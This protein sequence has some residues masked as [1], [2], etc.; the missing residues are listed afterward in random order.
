MPPSPARTSRRLSSKTADR[1]ACLSRVAVRAYVD[2]EEFD[3]TD[4]EENNLLHAAVKAG[5]RDVVR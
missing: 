5:S 2:G 3:A 4:D 1:N